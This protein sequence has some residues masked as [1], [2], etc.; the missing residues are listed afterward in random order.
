MLSDI[1]LSAIIILSV[2]RSIKMTDEE[3]SIQ[4]NK[5]IIT[6]AVLVLVFVV[7]ACIL[8]N[9][10]TN[11]TLYFHYV[12]NQNTGEPLSLIASI[13]L[14]ILFWWFI[15]LVPSASVFLFMMCLYYFL[16]RK[17]KRILDR[18]YHPKYEEEFYYG[19]TVSFAATYIA[20]LILMILHISNIATINVF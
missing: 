12:H 5:I 11:D 1:D 20:I 18:Y 4:K 7:V 14:Y 17:D 15:G 8:L 13:F 10:T 9:S 19:G 6:V 16:H 2:R 3:R